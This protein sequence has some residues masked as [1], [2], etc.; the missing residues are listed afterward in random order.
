ME[1]NEKLKLFEKYNKI[2]KVYKHNISFINMYIDDCID[3][4]WADFCGD[5]ITSNQYIFRM[6]NSLKSL[7]KKFI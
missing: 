7:I 3:Y 2:R 1:I 4:T 5:E 6:D